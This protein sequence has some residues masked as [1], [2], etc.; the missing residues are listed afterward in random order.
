MA[1]WL[2]CDPTVKAC[3][4]ELLFFDTAKESSK[5]KGMTFTIYIKQ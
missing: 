3:Q 1:K 2:L 5:K 4:I